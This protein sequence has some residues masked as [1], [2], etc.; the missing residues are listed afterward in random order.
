MERIFGPV[1]NTRENVHLIN[2]V[3]RQTQCTHTVVH[4]ILTPFVRHGVRVHGPG[5][6]S[7]DA[8]CVQ[9][10]EFTAKLVHFV[11]QPNYPSG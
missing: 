7:T 5:S 2:V 3:A 4:A 11:A 9:T 6:T 1:R 10:V 8:L